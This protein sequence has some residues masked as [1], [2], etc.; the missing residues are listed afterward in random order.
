M[1]RVY[2]PHPLISG[3]DNMKNRGTD[4]LKND[5]W[6]ANGT[7]I[8][9]GKGTMTVWKRQLLVLAVLIMCCEQPRADVLDVAPDGAVLRYDHA[10]AFNRVPI[11][12]EPQLR[13]DTAITA[14][15]A[16]RGL[17]A[18]AARRYSLDSQLLSAVAWRESGFRSGA[19]SAKGAVGIMQLMPETAR[20]LGVDRLDPA[21]NI[22]GGAAYLRQMLDRYHG[23]T[24]LALAAYNA[25]PGA[26]D[27]FGGI[28]P[29]SE[30]RNYVRG[31]LG[32]TVPAI[33]VS[34]IF[35]DP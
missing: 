20:Q 29:F 14:P 12:A 15:D 13:L 17:L 26:V 25:G 3:E 5:Y 34:V 28:P 6:H 1:R 27:R 19:T 11:G 22:E 8:R 4:G 23:N 2:A 35:V 32:A 9:R 24:S 33:P 10:A 31:T 7:T 18:S 30:T 21:Q 16:I